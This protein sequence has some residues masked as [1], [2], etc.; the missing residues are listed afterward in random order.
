MITSDCGFGKDLFG[1]RRWLAEQPIDKNDRNYCVQPFPAELV[2]VTKG[3]SAPSRASL[4]ART[5]VDRRRR[6]G[7]A[8]E[9]HLVAAHRAEAA[10]AMLTDFIE[11]ALGRHRGEMNVPDA[12][13]PVI[14][15]RDDARPVGAEGGGKDRTRVAAEDGDRLAGRGVPDARSLVVRRRDDARPVGAEGGG[16]DPI[17]VAAEDG[18]RV[19]GRGVPDARSL[20]ARRRDDAR[21]VG[22][23]GGGPDPILVAAEDGD[24][25]AGRGVPDARSLVARRRDDARPVG[26]EGG[27]KDRTRV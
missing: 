19:A 10:E 6:V 3:R 24:R 2:S 8:G 12:R 21:P 15:R 26:A 16:P 9:A 22:A 5:D 25:L 1:G 13:G 4:A 14:R 27:G 11:K 7:I 20:V 17:L 18:D 23:E